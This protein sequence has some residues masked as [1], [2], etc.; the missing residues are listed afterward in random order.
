MGAGVRRRLAVASV[1][2]AVIVGACTAAAPTP[3]P[4]GPVSPATSTH[5]AAPSVP[6]A[7][8]SASPTG[9]TRITWRIV[10]AAA[11]P[12]VAGASADPDSLY[13]DATIEGWRDGY[14][15]FVWQASTMVLTP[16]TSTDA[17][18]WSRGVAIDA[19]ALWTSE[20]AAANAANVNPDGPLDCSFFVAGWADDGQ[21]IVMRG[22]MICPVGCGSYWQTTE[23]MFASTTGASWTPLDEKKVFGARGLGL[24]SG[25]NA[26]FVALGSDGVAQVVWTSIDGLDWHRHAIPSALAAKGSW[27]SDT[28]SITGGLVLAGVRMV[29]GTAVAGPST[30]YLP[31]PSTTSCAVTVGPTPQ[32]L[33]EVYWSADGGA[34]TV[35]TLPGAVQGESVWVQLTKV[36][37]RTAVV[38]EDYSDLNDNGDSSGT[39]VWVTHDGM[40]WTS[41]PP[42][43]WS[44]GPLMPGRNE[45]YEC[46]FDSFHFTISVLS[47]DLR[48]ID[49]AADGDAP[50]KID[51]IFSWQVVAGPAG[52]LATED[53]TQLRL[54]V[55]H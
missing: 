35:S 52:L 5:S 54:G 38:T 43:K 22:R 39:V 33:P 32:Y 40:T 46:S 42:E 50:T 12:P 3:S 20:L 27:V 49:L 2:I 44:P 24:I 10:D 9:P 21:A 16:W 51:S 30:D 45:A 31:G 48:V 26:G 37:D 17:V 13:P 7:Q 47:D 18:T 11:A 4:S 28:A 23:M 55:V 14:V 25:G 15:E 8:P 29:S 41:Y 53:G 34:W 36:D 6:S 19:K 1:S